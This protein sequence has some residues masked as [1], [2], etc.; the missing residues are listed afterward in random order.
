MQLKRGKKLAFKMMDTVDG[1]AEFGMSE[2]V[3]MCCKEQSG[4]YHSA[5]EAA[6]LDFERRQSEIVRFI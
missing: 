6:A 4:N 3:K 2:A 1:A 5:L